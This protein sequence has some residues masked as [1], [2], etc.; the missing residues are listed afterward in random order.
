[1]APSAYRRRARVMV[2]VPGLPPPDLFP[3]CLNLM[4]MAFRN[5]GEAPGAA[6]SIQS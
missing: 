4:A 5:F 3:G 2:Q 6:A 1:V